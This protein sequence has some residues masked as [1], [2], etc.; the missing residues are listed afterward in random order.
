MA[1]KTMSRRQAIAAALTAAVA[2]AVGAVAPPPEP[3]PEP[4]VRVA[5]VRA[6]EAF[7][8]LAG[9]VEEYGDRLLEAEARWHG[10][11]ATV[12]WRLRG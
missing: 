3:M 4:C 8:F 12:S 6:E 2:A 9:L 5:E 1:E 11:V 10:G 7:R